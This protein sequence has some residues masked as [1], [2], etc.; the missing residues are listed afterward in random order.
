MR[1]A[2][3]SWGTLVSLA[4][5]PMALAQNAE[6]PSQPHGSS[7]SPNQNA[8]A[9]G[10]AK[11][12]EGRWN[13]AVWS[14]NSPAP[15]P[16]QG[17]ATS[18]LTASADWQAGRLYQRYDQQDLAMQSLMGGDGWVPAEILS[19]KAVFAGYPG[20]LIRY[21][22]EMRLDS[23]GDPLGWFWAVRS[24]D[25]FEWFAIDID[26]NRIEQRVLVGGVRCRD[27]DTI[28]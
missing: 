22:Y 14:P 13:P 24:E 23:D 6:P 1:L 15:E 5:G 20:I 9:P 26:D 18:A 4:M 25:A 17:C 19:Q 21:E 12:I 11:Y 10:I 7:Q 2:L 3:V 16:G 27:E 8:H 28:S